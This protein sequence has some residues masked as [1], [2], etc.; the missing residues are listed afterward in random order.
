MVFRRF[1]PE[2]FHEEVCGFQL[3]DRKAMGDCGKPAVGQLGINK[4][5]RQFLCEEHFRYGSAHLH[6][7]QIQEEKKID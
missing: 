7:T 2:N 1:H 3:W 6:D 5:Q 4:D